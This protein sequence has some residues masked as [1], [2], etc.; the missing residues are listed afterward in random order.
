MLALVFTAYVVRVGGDFMFGRFLIPVTP[1]FLV[2]FEL[3]IA[4]VFAGRPVLQWATLGIAAAGIAFTPYPLPRDPFGLVSGI[5]FE[6]NYYTPQ[7]TGQTRRE[8][9]TLRPFFDGLPI[10]MAFFGGEAR[11]V[12]YARPWV[13]IEC[14]TGLT[15]RTIAHQPLKQRGRIGHE[16]LASLDYLL[17]ERRAH[18]AVFRGTARALRLDEAI[19]AV[20]IEM[21]G[22][23]GRV[24]TW[25]PAVMDSLRARGASV[26]DF[27]AELDRL[28]AQP[29]LVVIW[30]GWT[31]REKLRRFYFGHVHDPSRQ[32]LV[33]QRVREAGG[34]EPGAE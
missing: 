12:Y 24:L 18:L 20:E 6:P 15:D 4:R 17:D 9:L 30:G 8:G 19:P 28:L 27:P 23:R 10:C 1:L 7:A 14:A 5:V 26:Q 25:D 21:G 31:V 29:G 3:G 11:L 2:L 16:K 22:V 32:A 34:G 33:D 13:A